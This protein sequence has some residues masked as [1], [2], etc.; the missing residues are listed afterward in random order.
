M[1]FHRL[2][3]RRKERNDILGE[4]DLPAPGALHSASCSYTASVKWWLCIVVY[5]QIPY[6]HLSGVESS[7]DFEVGLRA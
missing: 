7:M 5:I 6:Y 4:D 2:G 1:L 3:A